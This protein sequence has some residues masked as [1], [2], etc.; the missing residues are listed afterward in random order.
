MFLRMTEHL[1]RNFPGAIP[2]P[3]D[4]GRWLNSLETSWCCQEYHWLTGL[5]LP[6]DKQDDHFRRSD[7]SR[8]KPGNLGN[9]P[10]LNLSN[11]KIIRRCSITRGF[12][13][14]F[15][16]SW[17]HLADSTTSRKDEHVQV[18]GRGN[19]LL[20]VAEGILYCVCVPCFW[21]VDTMNKTYVTIGQ[22]SHW[23]FKEE[24]GEPRWLQA[25]KCL[26]TLG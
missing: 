24:R 5:K 20:W 25:R 4:D 23:S 17:K 13:A 22:W 10:C 9:P 1:M 21:I 2:A 3:T 15:K 8:L 19:A 14:G 16:C 12:E 7:W 26:E 18:I 11:T 6:K